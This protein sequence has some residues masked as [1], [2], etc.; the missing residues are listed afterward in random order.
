MTTGRTEGLLGGFL[1]LF[2]RDFHGLPAMTVPQCRGSQMWFE[3][4]LGF[5]LVDFWAEVWLPAGLFAVSLVFFWLETA[6]E[7]AEKPVGN[8]MSAQTS[9][10]KI[11]DGS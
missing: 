5:L 8:Q 10:K 7:T 6:R 11:R 1:G 3:G 2:D 4:R 9:T